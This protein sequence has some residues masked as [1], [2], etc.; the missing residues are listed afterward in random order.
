M[1]QTQSL[2]PLPPITHSVPFIELRQSFPSQIAAISPFV[3]QL[4]QFIL[5]F[6]TADG[7]EADIEMAL[8]EALANSV[9]HG[10]GENPSKH[11]YVECRCYMDGEVL[12]TVRDEGPGFDS[13]NVPDPTTPGR[14]S[15]THGRGIYLMRTLMDEVS[16]ED[17]GS[18]VRMR[19]NS[20]SRVTAQRK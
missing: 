18:I 13:E 8:Q 20:N 12:V 11:V 6:R 16:F 2:A 19:K 4:M 7:S 3:N 5:R 9:V 15:F 17:G 10:N 14:R 1:A